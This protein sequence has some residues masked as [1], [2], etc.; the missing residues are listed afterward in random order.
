MGIPIRISICV[1]T[2]TCARTKPY[3][4]LGPE[5][6]L[7]VAALSAQ[8]VLVDLEEDLPQGGVLEE[9]AHEDTDR[10]LAQ[11][12]VPQLFLSNEDAEFGGMESPGYVDDLDLSDEA[13]FI[14]L[15]SKRLALQVSPGEIPFPRVGIVLK[16]L[17]GPPRY[18]RV[19]VPLHEDGQVALQNGTQP[20]PGPHKTGARFV[21]RDS[22]DTR[23]F[24]K[25]VRSEKHTY[26]AGL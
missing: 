19:I 5:T 25:G 8:I 3:P 20:H 7:A 2:P 16:S 24:P 23:L 17:P 21:F 6:D 11:S 14:R 12:P 26:A 18:V 22:Q 4:S 1:P 10:L 9:S 15:D 13:V